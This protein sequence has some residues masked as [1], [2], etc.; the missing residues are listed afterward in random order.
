MIDDYDDDYVGFELLQERQYQK[1]INAQ[2][3]LHPHWGDPDYPE[4][5]DEG[6]D[7]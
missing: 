6:E 4:E 2:K 3:M 7:K 5:L 1:H